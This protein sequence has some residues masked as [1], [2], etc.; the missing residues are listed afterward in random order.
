MS[1]TGRRIGDA[2]KGHG[3]GLRKFHCEAVSAEVAPELLAEQNLHI[4]LVVDHENERVHARSPDLIR[5]A[6]ARGRTILKFGELTGLRI[7]LYR[8]AMLLDDDVVT[9][10]QAEPSPF[11]GR[12]GRKERVEQLLPHLGWNAGAVVAY[13]DFDPVAEVLGR[14]SKRRL[15]VATICFGFALRGCVEAVGD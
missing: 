15:I 5:D 9:D 3:G 12:L 14:G 13:P 7:D 6:P 1:D 2:L 10:G 4:G 8:P 11:T